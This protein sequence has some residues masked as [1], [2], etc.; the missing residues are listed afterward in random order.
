MASNPVTQ[1]TEA[2]AGNMTLIDGALL[3]ASKLAS[4]EILAR[5]PFVGNGTARSG[6]IKVGSAVF[7][8]MII[9]K[10]GKLGKAMSVVQ[11]GMLIDGMED[12][13]LFGKRMYQTKFG[14]GQKQ[15][16]DVSAFA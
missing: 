9:P 13:V 5:V 3:S 12:L 7:A 11:T 8:S 16:G 4:E 1:I 2:K 10:K 15:S 6:L 14:Q